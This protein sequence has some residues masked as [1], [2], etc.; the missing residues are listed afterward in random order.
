M[1]E[2]VKNTSANSDFKNKDSNQ[3]HLKFP[4]FLIL[5]FKKFWL[6]SNKVSSRNFRHPITAVSRQESEMR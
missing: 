6:N 4:F 1:I 5:Y 2:Q 3:V